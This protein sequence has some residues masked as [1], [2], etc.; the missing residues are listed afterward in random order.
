MAPPLRILHFSDL[1]LGLHIRHMDWRKWLS[2]RAVGAINLLRGRARYFAGAEEKI[3]ALIRF[4]EKEQVDLLIN[5]GDYT[6]LGLESEM[7]LAREMVSPLL[8]PPRHYLTVPGNHDLYVS[9]RRGGQRFAE[10]FAGVLE[11]DMAEY[12]REGPWPLVRLVG[13]EV[14]VIMV[15]SSRP[16]RRPWKSS[17]HI[18]S[19]Q[20]A[21]LAAILA[22]ERLQGRFVCIATHYAPRLADGRPDT[23]LHGLSNGDDF[24]AVCQRVSA[25]AI[26]CGHVHETYRVRVAGLASEIFCAGSATMAGREGFWLYEIGDG[27]LQATRFGWDGQGYGPA[28]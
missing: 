15:N 12:C 10:L 5:T 27:Q 6:A 18:S 26:L 23:A 17:G 9:R 20:L 13:R 11:S 25:G 16:N 22:D 14:A 21:A 4:Q 28:A 3:T 7:L 1:H 24:L 8:T 2:K 19:A